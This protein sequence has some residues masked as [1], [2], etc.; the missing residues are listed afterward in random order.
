MEIPYIN[1]N[2]TFRKYG[3]A[4]LLSL[5]LLG[6]VAAPSLAAN[7]VICSV[8]EVRASD[9]NGNKFLASFA[10]GGV[11]DEDLKLINDGDVNNPAHWRYKGGDNRNGKDEN[12]TATSGVDN[13]WIA[14]DL[15]TVKSGLQMNFANLDTEPPQTSLGENTNRGINQADIYYRSDSFGSNVHNVTNHVPF[16]ADGWTLFGTAG[17]Q[18]FDRTPDGNGIHPFKLI[19]LGVSARYIAIDVNSNH[20]ADGKVGLNE[21]QF[22]ATAV[23]EPS[24]FALLTGLLALTWISL[25]HRR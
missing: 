5:A 19:D 6:F 14:F 11:L 22:F 4:A 18:T 15:G 3:L 8:D 10:V 16:N 23:P 12:W 25:R 13:Q 2:K 20:G 1:Q 7:V 9:Q 21:V 24:S 17:E